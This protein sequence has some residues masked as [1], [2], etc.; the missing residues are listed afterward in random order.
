MQRYR[1]WPTYLH[2]PLVEIPWEMLNAHAQ[3]DDNIYTN[4]IQKLLMSRH[5][6]ID[7][8]LVLV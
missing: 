6:A 8:L 5:L 4:S 1:P 3:C 2:N 7:G